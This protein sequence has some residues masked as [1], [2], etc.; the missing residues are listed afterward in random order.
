MTG[1][2]GGLL[3]EST[4]SDWKATAANQMYSNDLEA[5]GMKCCYFLF[6]SKVNFFMRSLFSGEQQWPFG[7]LVSFALGNERTLVTCIPCDARSAS[8][9]LTSDKCPFISQ[10]KRKIVYFN[11]YNYAKAMKIP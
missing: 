2:G 8:Q 4:S 11:P 5:C 6:H 1:W 9:R 10:C 3:Q 7:P